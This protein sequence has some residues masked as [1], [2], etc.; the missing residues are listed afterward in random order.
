MIAGEGPV[1][2]ANRSVSRSAEERIDLDAATASEAV[3]IESGKHELSRLGD[4]PENIIIISL[5]L[6]HLDILVVYLNGLPVENSKLAKIGE[7]SAA[8]AVG[9]VAHSLGLR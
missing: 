9:Q 1:L 5:S 7:D 2:R 8:V 3:L 6:S 4:L